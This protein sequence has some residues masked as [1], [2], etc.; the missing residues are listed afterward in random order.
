MLT[1]SSAIQLTSE[2]W[3]CE[4]DNN[5]IHPKSQKTCEIC[6]SW[7]ESQPNSTVSEVIKSGYPV[8]GPRPLYDGA[9]WIMEL[10]PELRGPGRCISQFGIRVADL[11]AE[12]FLGIYHLDHKALKKADW[13][14]Q[15]YIAFNLGVRQLASA[16]FNELTRLTF[17]A[18]HLSVRVAIDG[19]SFRHLKITFHPRI[20]NGH[21]TDSHPTLE[22][23]VTRFEQEMASHQ[24]SEVK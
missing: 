23:A 7:Q 5:Y 16:D 12:L 9:S 3:D 17:L 2:Y 22:E 1:N 24:L 21:Y 13:S 6:K 11:L 20:R 10:A 15:N 8:L 4:C 14:N 18:H 19:L